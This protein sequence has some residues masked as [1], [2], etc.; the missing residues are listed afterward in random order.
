MAKSSA[1][2]AEVTKL[3]LRGQGVAVTATGTEFAVLDVTDAD[4]EQTFIQKTPTA[5]RRFYK[6]AQA[7]RELLE[8]GSFSAVWGAVREAG[9]ATHCFCA[10]D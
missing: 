5:A 9:I 3:S 2:K 1:L 10:V 6:W 8:S 7:N 4:N